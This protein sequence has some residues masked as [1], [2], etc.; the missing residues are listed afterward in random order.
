MRGRLFRGPGPG[1]RAPLRPLPIPD[2]PFPHVR[3]PHPASRRPDRRIT[4]RT[5]WA[6]DGVPGRRARSRQ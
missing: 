2:C 6:A 5:W 4:A 1:S 3:C